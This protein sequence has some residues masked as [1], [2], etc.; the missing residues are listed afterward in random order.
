MFPREQTCETPALSL[1]QQ[2]TEQIEATTTNLISLGLRLGLA[3]VEQIEAIN[4]IIPSEIWPLGKTLAP[5]DVERDPP[6]P[7]QE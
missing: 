4:K 2:W 6:T 7:Y 5:W 3:E 1:E